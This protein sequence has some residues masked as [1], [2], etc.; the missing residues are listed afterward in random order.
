MNRKK[1][2]TILIVIATV[3]LA[4]IAIFTAVRLYQL[5]NEPVAPTAPTSKPEAATPQTQSC[6]TLAFTIGGESPTPTPTDSPTP[7]PSESPT[8]TPPIRRVCMSC[9]KTC[10]IPPHLFL[11]SPENIKSMICQKHWQISQQINQRWNNSKP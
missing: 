8:A 1:I 11:H 10:V 2:L 5:R 7:T 9:I 3:I 4:G 6:T